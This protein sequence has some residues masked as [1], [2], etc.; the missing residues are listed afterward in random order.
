M[1]APL[2]TVKRFSRWKCLRHRLEAALLAPALWVIPFFPYQAVRCGGRCAGWLSYWFLGHPRRIALANLDVA[3][4]ETKTRLEKT[5]IARASFQSFGAAM[6]GLFWSAR[7]TPALTKQIVD[8]HDSSL[9][10]IRDCM[11]RGKGVIFIMMHYG[12]WELQGP[13]FGFQEIP[14]TVIAKRMSNPAL[15]RIFVQLRS[16]WG[17]RVV[18]GPYAMLRLL[19]T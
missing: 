8:V 1:S 3:F 13:A 4:G 10:M 16:Q 14:M 2:K 17:H 11:A 9:Q 19:K 6:L 12:D 15:E 18:A 7:L 5:R